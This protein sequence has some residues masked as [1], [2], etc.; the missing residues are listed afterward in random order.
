MRIA[1]KIEIKGLVQGVGFRPFIYRLA[2][3]FWLTGTVENNNTGVQVVVEGLEKNIL[4]FEKT[5]PES[6]PEAASISIMNS[7][8]IKLKG[9]SDFSIIKSSSFSDEITEVSPDIGVCKACL[10]D[11]QSQAHRID[12]PF[13]NC[14]N[15]GPRF[16]IIKDLPYDRD[17]TTMSVFEMCEIC[18]KEYADINDRRFHAQ[19]VA[20]NHCGPEY[21]LHI[22]E[23]VFSNIHEIISKTSSL[24]EAGKIVAMKGLGGYHLATNPFKNDSVSELRQR[25]NRDGKPFALMFKNLESVKEY[26]HVNEQE[27]VLITNWKKPIALLKTKKNFAPS[28]S[29]GLN[30]VGAMLPYLPFHYMLF[31]KINLRQL[32]L[33]AAIFLTNPF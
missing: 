16:T 28:V 19:P 25:K 21:S 30:T 23:S 29:I 33:P 1:K 18:K 4:S 17:K 6:I 27:E 13:T 12:Y 11:M 24:L 2:S 8:E 26:L 15:C 32:S 9:Y 22:G 14:T 31:Q 20:C 10:D 3:Q 7:T 5:L